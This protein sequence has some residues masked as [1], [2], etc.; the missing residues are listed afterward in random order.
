M[1]CPV[2]ESVVQ[3]K[4][5]FCPECGIN[6]KEFKRPYG[7]YSIERLRQPWVEKGGEVFYKKFKAV[8]NVGTAPYA[9]IKPIRPILGDFIGVHFSNIKTFS[10]SSIQPRCTGELCEMYR[11]IGYHSVDHAL[12]TMKLSKVVDLVGRTGLFWKVVDNSEVHKMLTRGWGEVHQGVVSLVSIDRRGLQIKFRVDEGQLAY[13][14]SDAT[15]FMTLNILGGNLEA[16]CNMKCIGTEVRRGDEKYFEYQLHPKTGEIDYPLP[17]AD[18]DEYERIFEKLVGDIVENKPSGR[19]K[20]KDI[21]H[22]SG[23]QVEVFYMMRATEGHRILEKYS[24]VKCGKTLAQKAGLHKEEEVWDFARNVFK[25]QK[26]GLLQKPTKV[27]EGRVNI[28]LTESAYSAGVSDI[29][30]KLDLF[31]AGIIEGLLV[32]STGERWQVDEK[33]CI[34]NGDGCCEF[35]AKVREH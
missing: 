33:L 19:V 23:E 27:S 29:G 1:K 32:Q 31:I 17:S 26:V 13:L 22:I 12:R 10:L 30:M 9:K 3:S 28:E 5:K 35:T 8:E 11:M 21:V 16:L 34:A 6:A 14:G 20:L 4:W 24:G 7:G 15:D 2:C 18:E 25:Q